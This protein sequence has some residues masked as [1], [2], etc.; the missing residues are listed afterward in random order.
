MTTKI[1]IVNEGPGDIIIEQFVDDLNRTVQKKIR[2]KAGM[3]SP[4]FGSYVHSTSRYTVREYGF[5]PHCRV[6]GKRE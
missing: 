3:I 5:E 6:Q 2:V 4:D 1:R